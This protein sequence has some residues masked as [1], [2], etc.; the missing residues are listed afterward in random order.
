[1]W[2]IAAPQKKEKDINANH[3]VYET[4]TGE[5]A[6]DD[7]S[8]WDTFYKNKNNPFGKEPITFL[9]QHLKN[10]PKGRALV[11]AMGE[12]R[13]AIYLAK[14]GFQVEGVDISEVAVQKA[15]A[16]A[17]L[18]HVNIKASAEDLNDYHFQDNYY[19]L[20]VICQFYSAALVPQFKKSVK[21]GGYIMFYNKLDVQ[22]AATAG[23]TTTPDEFTVKSGE[24]KEILKDFQVKEYREFKD[25]GTRI[26]AILAKKP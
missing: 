25:Q 15:L 13:N 3:A 9:K 16:D 17:K 18:L 12:G 14:N 8:A 4:V 22:D 24:L 11:P 19:D 7:K 21:K 23:R 26:A 5:S 20:I 10:I 2:V 1:M 6:D